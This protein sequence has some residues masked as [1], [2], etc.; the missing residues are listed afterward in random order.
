MKTNNNRT[1]RKGARFIVT[2]WRYLIPQDNAR[3]LSALIALAV[4]T[5]ITHMNELEKSQS[6]SMR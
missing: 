1:T 2:T 4:E 5:E 3:S 6:F